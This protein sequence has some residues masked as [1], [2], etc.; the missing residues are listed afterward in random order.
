MRESQG[1]GRV[2]GRRVGEE[3]EGREGGESMSARQCYHTII[4]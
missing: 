2:E 3:S 1:R 4:S